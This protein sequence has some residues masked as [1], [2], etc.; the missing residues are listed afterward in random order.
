MTAKNNEVKIRGAQGATNEILKM[1]NMNK[2][3]EFL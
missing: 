2:L 1:A 3:F